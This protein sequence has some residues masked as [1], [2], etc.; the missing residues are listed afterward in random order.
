[1]RNFALN[2][3]YETL[4]RKLYY[5]KYD[6]NYFFSMQRSKELCRGKTFV[7]SFYETAGMAKVICFS[8]TFF[9]AERSARKAELLSFDC[10]GRF[11]L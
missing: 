6:E 2:V 4:Q 1:M 8:F 10:C 11:F 5:R 3:T 7:G 9:M